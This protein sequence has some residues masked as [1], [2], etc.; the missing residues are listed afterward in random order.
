MKQSSEFKRMDLLFIYKYTLANSIYQSDTRK[1]NRN[2]FSCLC[3]EITWSSLFNILLWSGNTTIFNFSSKHKFYLFDT[4]MQALSSQISTS[5]QA[6]VNIYHSVPTHAHTHT[7]IVLYCFH[8]AFYQ[9]RSYDLKIFASKMFW[10]L[11]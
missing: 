9:R 10:W 8:I 3:L 5:P 7:S 2:S 11:H 6:F 1:H 4:S